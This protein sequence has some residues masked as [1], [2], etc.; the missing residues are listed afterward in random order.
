MDYMTPSY[1]VYNSIQDLRI[2]ANNFD[3]TP[4]AIQLVASNQ[5]H[6]LAS[7]DPM[8]HLT[9][10]MCARA[11]F[12]ANEVSDDAQYL[13]LFPFSLSGEAVKWIDS[14]PRHHFNTW[15]QLKQ[16]FLKEYF[17]L[18][19]TIKLKRRIQNFHQSPLESLSEAW[20]IFKAI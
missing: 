3:I 10:F 19:K 5:F 18:M 6:G 12:K 1:D 9:R 8:A 4:T 15:D 17:P 20:K 16:E 14:L 11:L 2:E 13:L 7:E